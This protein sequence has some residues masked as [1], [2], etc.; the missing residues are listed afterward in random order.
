MLVS[1]SLGMSDRA[2]LTMDYFICVPPL[3]VSKI[4][5]TFIIFYC[6]VVVAFPS[7]EHCQSPTHPAYDICNCTSI[8][9]CIT[10][11]ERIA[12]VSAPCSMQSHAL[13]LGNFSYINLFTAPACHISGLKDARTR[14]QTIYFPVL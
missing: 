3:I 9:K 4:I 5:N 14:L 1:V 2:F 7:T 11:A 13:L 6:I 12:R 10:Q 8:A